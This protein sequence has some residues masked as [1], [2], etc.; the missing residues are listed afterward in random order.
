MRKYGKKILGIVAAATMLCSVAMTAG[1]GSVKFDFVKPDD[2]VYS[3][4]DGAV[5]SNGGF[6]VEKGGYVY[7]IN[8]VESNTADNTYGAVEKGALMRIGKAQLKAGEYDKAE[9]VVPSLLVAKNYDAGIYVFDDTVYYATPTT[10]KNLEGQVENS[11]LDFK[12]ANL[13]TGEVKKDKFFHV[14]SSSLKNYR[15]VKQGEDVYCLYEEDT[16]LKSYNTST[17]KTTVL[18]KGASGYFYDN[19]DVNNGNVYYTM[20]VT[21]NIASDIAS[22]TSDYNQLYCVNVADVAKDVGKNAAYD[23]KVGYTVA[24]T[25]KQY[26]FDGKWLEDNQDGYKV[27]DY[28]TYPYVNLGELVLDG[29]GSKF[30]DEIYN[31]GWFNEDKV[32]DSLEFKGYTYTVTRYENGGVYFTRST[33]SKLYYL[34]DTKGADWNTIT[35]N[36]AEATAELDIVSLNTTNAS[37]TALFEVSTDNAGVRTHSYIYKSGNEVYKATAKENGEQDVLVAIVRNVTTANL[38]KTEG[39]YLYYYADY[40]NGNSLS[41]V[42]YTGDEDSYNTFHAEE[43][44]YEDYQPVTLPLV[45]WSKDWYKPELIDVDGETVLLYANTQKYGNSTVTYNYVYAAKVGTTADIKASIEKYEAYQDYLEEYSTK[46]D[47]QNLI[48]YFFSAN[49]IFAGEEMTLSQ[50]TIDLYKDESQAEDKQDALYQEV[51]GKFTAEEGKTAELATEREFIGL[52][53]KVTE[54]DLEDIQTAWKD[55]LLKPEPKDEDDDSLPGWAIALIVVG[56]V[57]IVAAGAAV[58]VVIYFKKKAAAKKEEE[59][60]VNAYRRQKIDTTDDKTIDVYADEEKKEDAAESTETAEEPAPEA[61]AEEAAEPTVE[62][63]EEKTE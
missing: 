53:G 9:I 36:D 61:Q 50:E 11:Y 63:E 19:K 58:P 21:Y 37:S 42:N 12:C 38:W 59:A 6:A 29:V 24:D 51:L 48:K 33:D 35:G 31:G 23:G 17:G 8:G 52:V 27:G 62:T 28:T 22:Q 16:T 57:L 7:F 5:G 30:S 56:A 39:D 60:I 18:V 49:T 55:T 32:E 34:S 2:A 43:P 10:D 40:N 44:G 3:A 47:A 26:T 45:E 41:R 13:K 25:G 54:S 15:F 1:C 46:T 14:D 4:N 20:P